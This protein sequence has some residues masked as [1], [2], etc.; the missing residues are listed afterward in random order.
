MGPHRQLVKY[1]AK[2][3]HI[4]QLSDQLASLKAYFFLIHQLLVFAELA[5]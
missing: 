4:V 3:T 2:I 5:T 1:N